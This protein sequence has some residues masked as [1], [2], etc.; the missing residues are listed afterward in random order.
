M[1]KQPSKKRKTMSQPYGS[2]TN[3]RYSS[4]PRT[5]RTFNYV[6]RVPG[7]PM[8]I[9]ERK[10][11]DSELSAKA[12]PTLASDWS[13]SECDPAAINNLFSPTTGTNFNNRIGRKV[14]IKSLRIHGYVE[15]IAQEMLS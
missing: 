6:P 8:S 12:L 1:P 10:Y 9:T 7:N 3:K 2:T 11:F 14:C 13:R 15:Y 5:G 4:Q